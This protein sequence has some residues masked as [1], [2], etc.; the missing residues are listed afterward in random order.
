MWGLSK[1]RFLQLAGLSIANR[2]LRGRLGAQ[3][4]TS[5]GSTKRVIIVT[6]GGG[7][8]YSE[9]FAPEGLRNIP[10]LVELRPRGYFFQSC[11]NS[12][13]LSHFNSTASILTGN[14]QRVDDFGFQPPA[15]AT[16][17]EYY[18]KQS[19]AGPLDAWAVATNKSFASMGSS[20]D[21]AFGAP[22]GA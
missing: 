18:R 2:I 19:G 16:L 10:R 13:V 4:P 20:S 21:R 14:W 1:R 12:G 9:T 5:R 15:G 7:V 22:Y 6:F 11:T 3:E 8:R 17:F